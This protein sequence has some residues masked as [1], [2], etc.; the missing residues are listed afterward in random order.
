MVQNRK[1]ETAFLSETEYTCIERR[2]TVRPLFS[3]RL[4]TKICGD[5][6]KKRQSK[7]SDEN[8]VIATHSDTKLNSN[9]FTPN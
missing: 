7:S 2:K 1:I 6:T 5:A 9:R 3:Q 8:S 4:A